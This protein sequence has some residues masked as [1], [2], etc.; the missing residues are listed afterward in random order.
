MNKI[1]NRM[2]TKANHIKELKSIKWVISY[3]VKDND[4]KK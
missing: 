4:F 3:I 1:L 2:A